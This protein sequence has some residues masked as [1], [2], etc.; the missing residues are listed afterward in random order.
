MA[1]AKRSVVVRK[2]LFFKMGSGVIAPMNIIFKYFM[3]EVLRKKENNLLS[4]WF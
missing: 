2:N 3:G 4:L 1:D